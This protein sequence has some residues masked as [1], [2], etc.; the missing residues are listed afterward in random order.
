MARGPFRLSLGVRKMSGPNRVK[1]K[2]KNGELNKQNM[3]SLNPA[4]VTKY[5]VTAPPFDWKIYEQLS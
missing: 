1:I 3:I 5:S 4:A 2:D